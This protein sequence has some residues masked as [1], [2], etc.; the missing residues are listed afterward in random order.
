M[1]IIMFYGAECPHCHVM[2]PY[3]DRLIKEEKVKVEKLEVWHSEKNADKMRKHEAIISEAS[4]GMF[5][6]P[7]FIDEKGKK[8]LCGEVS[9]EE[10]KG[11]VLGKKK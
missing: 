6:V 9:Y 3:V 2:M 4:G 7:A 10:L 8:A 5:G 1:K 11:W